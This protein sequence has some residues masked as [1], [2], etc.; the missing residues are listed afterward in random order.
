[1][2]HLRLLIVGGVLVAIGM[3]LGKQTLPDV[4]RYRRMR[5]M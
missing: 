3:A 5:A 4:Q 1:M 2:R